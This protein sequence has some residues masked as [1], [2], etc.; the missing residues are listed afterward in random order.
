MMRL[1]LL[2]LALAACSPAVAS[3]PCG[4]PVPQHTDAPNPYKFG[5][6]GHPWNYKPYYFAFAKSQG[7]Q[8]VRMDYDGNDVYAADAGKSTYHVDFSKEDKITQAILDSGMTELPAIIQYGLPPHMAPCPHCIWKTA[9]DYAAYVTLTVTHLKKFPQITRIELLNEPNQCYWW[10]TATYGC[11]NLDNGTDAA[12]YLKAGYAAAKKANP[13]I[14]VV[15]VALANGGH[16]GKT[17]PLDYFANMY[18]EG[19]KTGVCWDVVSVHNF[20]WGIDP[21]KGCKSARDMNCWDNYKNVQAVASAHGDKNLHVMLTE[22]GWCTDQSQWH[23]TDVPTAAKYFSE[24][25]QDCLKNP[26]C[27][28]FNNASIVD[29]DDGGVQFGSIGLG[30]VVNG[31]IVAKF[32]R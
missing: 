11:T 24:G 22:T 26:T 30:A 15:A 4:N 7:A 21:A 31:K 19:C 23:C 18:V 32:P 8:Y 3:I 28:G 20:A 29:G 27:D 12:T 6:M 13:H 16:I 14:T 17:S 9:D 2:C 25:K 10:I 5:A 1:L